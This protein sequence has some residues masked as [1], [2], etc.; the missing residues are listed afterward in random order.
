MSIILKMLSKKVPPLGSTF[1]FFLNLS[2]CET[3]DAHGAGTDVYTDNGADDVDFKGDFCKFF[4]DFLL[5]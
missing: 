2:V 3:G 1:N 5:Q 4:L